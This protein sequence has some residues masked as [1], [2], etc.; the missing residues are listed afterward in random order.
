MND[1]ADRPLATDGTASVTYRVDEACFMRACH[2][3]WDYRAIGR[4]GN[5]VVAGIVGLLG[6]SLVWLDFTGPAPYF[7]LAC[8]ILF[9]GVTQLR[10]LLWR[11]H[12]RKIDKYKGPITTI[13]SNSGIE[14][15][16]PHNAHAVQWSIFTGYLRTDEFLLLV[17]NQKQFSVIPLSAFETITDSGYF[18]RFITNHLPIMKK[19]YL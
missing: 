12:Y 18:E 7:L 11:R 3:L 17:I 9:V 8:S 2:A 14:V 4:F 6:L 5:L 13:L 1:Q 16:L 19:R 10:D 15:V